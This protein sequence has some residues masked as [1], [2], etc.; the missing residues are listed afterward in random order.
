M[1]H[2]LPLKG[3]MKMADLI[4][5]DYRLIPVIGRFGIN[6]GF[7]NK[8]VSE[9][10]EQNDINVKFFLEIVNSYHDK[11]YFPRSELQSFQV[12]LIT[13][14]LSRT[15]DYYL[16]VKIPEIQ[17]LIDQMEEKVLVKNRKNIQ[18]LNEFFKSYQ[19]ELRKHLDNEES[20]IFPYINELEKAVLF[21]ESNHWLVSKIRE[22]T[23]ET[24]ERNHDSLEVKLSDLKN[25]IMKYL[26]P[27]LCSELCRKLL[28]E[29]FLLESDLNNHARIEDKVLI[30]KVKQ[31]EKTALKIFEKAG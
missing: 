16:K 24:Y 10:C 6:Y 23:I 28:M 22:K 8:P 7:G 11:E 12:S 2:R 9:V 29:L 15:H 21:K 1:N 5:R 14:Y 18:L 3:T 4:H 19:T 25:L 17:S 31:L 30:P 27:V 20:N 13:G 26:P